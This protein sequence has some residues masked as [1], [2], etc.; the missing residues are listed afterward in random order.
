MTEM[1]QELLYF[2]NVTT[3]DPGVQ[4]L[5]YVSFYLKKGETLGVTGLNGG[6]MSCLADVLCGKIQPISGGIYIDNE[7]KIISSEEDARKLGIH[8]ISSFHSIIPT[9]TAAE[10]LFLPDP[11]EGKV[12]ISKHYYAVKTRDFLEEYDLQIDGEALAGG[13]SYAN[14]LEIAICRAVV[15]G[16]RIIIC[17]DLGAG[18]TENE[19]TA[20]RELIRKICN[21]GISVILF[22]SASCKINL[23]N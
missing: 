6:G 2:Q 11:M 13:L 5:Q 16:A 15:R 1:D 10:N 22:N 20:C 23:N 3:A 12:F 4:N 7:K 8:E 21:L 19:I 17:H 18:F 9:L 14:R